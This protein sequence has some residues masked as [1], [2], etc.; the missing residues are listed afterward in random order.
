MILLPIISFLGFCLALSLAA[1]WAIEALPLLTASALI[2]ALYLAAL[3]G[4]L[5][6]AAKRCFGRD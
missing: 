1:G 2:A 5:A 6:A 4:A 3:A